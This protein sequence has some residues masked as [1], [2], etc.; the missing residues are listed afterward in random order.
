MPD[1]PVTGL[2]VGGITQEAWSQGWM[3][4]LTLASTEEELTVCCWKF[5]S[6]TELVRNAVI[7]GLASKDSLS[8]TE[9]KDQGLVTVTSNQGTSI[10]MQIR[11]L[12]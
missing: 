10:S 2:T 8:E 9:H 11:Q 6:P 12:R 5:S 7:Q 1:S 4:L 3:C